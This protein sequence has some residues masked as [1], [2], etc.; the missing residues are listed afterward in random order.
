MLRVWS[1]QKEGIWVEGSLY[2][3]LE[4]GQRV[5]LWSCRPIVWMKCLNYSQ[6]KRWNLNSSETFFE[7]F[8]KCGNDWV[9]FERQL[10]ENGRPIWLMLMTVKDE[11]QGKSW[12]ASVKMPRMRPTFP[13]CSVENLMKGQSLSSSKLPTSFRSNLIVLYIVR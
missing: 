13:F 7:I 3:T 5:R 12:I 9:N 11:S 2:W 1:N 10:Q 8:T 4:E 6:V